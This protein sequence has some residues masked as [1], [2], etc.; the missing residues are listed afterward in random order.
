[1]TTTLSTDIDTPDYVDEPLSLYQRA[2]TA[3][4]LASLFCQ[5][6]GAPLIDGE[7]KPS[8]QVKA[9]YAALMA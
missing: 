3:L 2:Q 5:E 7:G 8:E 6:K 9:V 1:M 4:T